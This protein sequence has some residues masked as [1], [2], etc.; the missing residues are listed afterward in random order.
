MTGGGGENGAP[1]VFKTVDE[2]FFD[3]IDCLCGRFVGLSP[4]EILNRPTREVYDLYADVVI[5]DMRE[6]NG[7]NKQEV[8]VTSKNATWH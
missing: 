6:K 7:N 4:F 2:S 8:W 5:H 1:P 3:L